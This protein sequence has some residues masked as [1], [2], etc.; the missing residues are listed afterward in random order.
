MRAR[1]GV[2]YKWIQFFIT[3]LKKRQNA[4]GRYILGVLLGFMPCGLVVSALMASASAP[5]V[6]ES[7]TAMAA[8]TIG[9]IPALIMVAFGGKAI[10]MKYPKA[11]HFVSRG[12]MVVSAVWL[13]TL[14]GSLML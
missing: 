14:A 3:R 1:L 5:T 12:G 8:F 2:P 10:S 4:L 9:T 7:A 11:T 13:F 6:F